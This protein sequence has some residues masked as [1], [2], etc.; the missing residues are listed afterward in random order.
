MKMAAAGRL[1]MLRNGAEALFELD[2]LH[3]AERYQQQRDDKQDI[4]VDKAA[5]RADQRNQSAH[6]GDDEQTQHVEFSAQN[7]IF[8]ALTLGWFLTHA[9]TFLPGKWLFN[10]PYNIFFRRKKENPF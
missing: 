4:R 10:K 8:E 7:E 3:K 6:H 1:E 9:M 5:N 2:G